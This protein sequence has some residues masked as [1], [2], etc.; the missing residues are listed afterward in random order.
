MS[1]GPI[2]S[3]PAGQGQDLLAEDL[4]RLVVEGHPLGAHDAVVTV[5][6]IG[7][8]GHIGHHGHVGVFPLEDD[9]IL[10]RHWM[11]T[12]NRHTGGVPRQQ[13]QDPGQLVK[14]VQ[15]LDAMRGQP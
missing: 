11:A 8:Q 7:I 6:G 14:M 4:H 3:A 1:L 9:V 12:P 10:M 15:Y 2:R 13:L 5:T